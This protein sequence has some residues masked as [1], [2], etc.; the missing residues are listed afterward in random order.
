[1]TL[2]MREIIRWSRDREWMVVASTVATVIMVVTEALSDGLDN[3]DA[4]V[5][6]I[7]VVMG[8]LMAVV[9]SNVWSKASVDKLEG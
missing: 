5:P 9:R 1:M 2:R 7:V 4:G 3:L 8:V 6:V